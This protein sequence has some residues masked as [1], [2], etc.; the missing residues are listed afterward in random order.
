[1]MATLPLWYEIQSRS[2]YTVVV[3]PGLSHCNIVGFTIAPLTGWLIKGFIR[4]V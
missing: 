4:V 3:R 2:R 1:M